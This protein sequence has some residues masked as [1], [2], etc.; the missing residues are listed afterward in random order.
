MPVI[1]DGNGKMGLVANL[2][3]PPVISCNPDAPCAQRGCYAKSFKRF[4]PC[5]KMWTK[6]WRQWQRRPDVYERQVEEYLNTWEVPIFRWHVAG[7][8]PDSDYWEM[9]LRIARQFPTVKFLV[10]TKQYDLIKGRVPSNMSVVLS[11]W[12]GL[13]IPV[14]LRRR[15]QV[16]WL[17][18][19]NQP[20]E[21]IPKTALECHGNCERCGICWELNNLGRDVVF[22]RH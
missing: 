13:H 12:P 16:A 7:D 17:R 6:N 2:S 5:V 19:R 4:P 8:I 20:D 14:A 9:M 11:A 1:V 3:L 21:R 10:F 18:D 22:N 15:F